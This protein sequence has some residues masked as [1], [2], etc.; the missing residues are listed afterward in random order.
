[1]LLTEF[2]YEAIFQQDGSTLVPRTIIQEPAIWLYV[3]GFGTKKDDHC[4]VA[5]IDKKIVGAAWVRCVKGFGQI[6]ETAPEL[7]ISIYSEYR[8]RGI[9]TQ[10]MKEML[11]LLKSKGYVKTSLAV[12]KDNYAVKMYQNVGFEI[13]TQNEDEYIMVCE[14]NSL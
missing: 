3:E 14:L 4:L 2:L 10:L 5:E 8:G 6:D 12:Q 11:E 13:S 7:A 9:G 1:M